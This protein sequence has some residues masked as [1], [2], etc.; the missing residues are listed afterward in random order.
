MDKKTLRKAVEEVKERCGV[1]HFS[2]RLIKNLSGGY[3]QRVGIAQAIVH[4]PKLV[5]LDEPTTGLDPNQLLET[6]NLI[7]EIAVDH[8]VLLSS[9]ILSEIHLLCKDIIMI[10]GGRVIFSD[11]MEAF[12]GYLQPNN[13]LMKLETP[14]PE[15]ELLKIEGVIKVEF[16][17]E[18]QIR[19]FFD[20]EEGITERLVEASV[21]HGW[22]LKEIGFEKGVLDETFRQLS[23]QTNH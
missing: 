8:C 12:N 23:L 10:E 7:K 17:A 21:R 15:T 6:R 16:L 14:P 11:S 2:N 4:K 20:K 13:I 5:V 19:V 3:K 22:K 1:A 18:Q 9:H